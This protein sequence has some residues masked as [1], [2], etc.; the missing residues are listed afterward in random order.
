MKWIELIYRK[1][2]M[3]SLKAVYNNFDSLSDNT[4]KDVLL[5]GDPSLDQK[6]NKFILEATIVYIKISERFSESLFE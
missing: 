6:R 4:K 3:N 5:Y 1:D 2:L